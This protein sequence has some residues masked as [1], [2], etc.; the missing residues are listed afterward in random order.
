MDI[1]HRYFTES[2]EIFTGNA[3]ITDVFTD[4]WNP[5]VFYRELKNIYWE[6]HN[7]QRLHR[8]MESVGILQRA[9]KYLLGMPQSPTS[10]QTDGVR[11]HFTKS[12]KIFTRN[13]TI[14]DVF[15]D[16]WSPLVFNQELK[17]IYW[18]CHYHWRNKSIDIFQAE[19]FLPRIFRL[20]N[21]QQ[22]F[23]FTE[24]VSNGM[25]DYPWKACRRTLS[26][27]DVVDTKFTDGVWISH[28][29]IQSFG[30]TMKSCR[31]SNIYKILMTTYIN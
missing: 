22:Y 28:R 3:T 21:H 1:V 9:E 27:D 12:W 14:T 11:R 4:G 24:R 30:N 25:W 18:I 26:V 29:R 20:Q 19:F 17:N 8:W 15:T 7:H 10:S 16:G 2:W 23:F 31:M 6:C 5:S 13:A